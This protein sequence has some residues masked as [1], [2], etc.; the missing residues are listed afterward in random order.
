MHVVD[1]KP[2]TVDELVEPV[3]TSIVEASR[4]AGV[5]PIDGIKG[6]SQGIIQ[7][8]AET[9]I[10]LSEATKRILEAARKIAEQMGIPEE[11]AIIKAAE[12][13]LSAAEE[14]G[15]EAAAEVVDDLP[16][17]IFSEHEKRQKSQEN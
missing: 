2:L 9:G 13:V 12:G 1:E 17:K 7:G 5:K 10:D 15:P 11:E 3:A 14:I 8:A 4:N 6:V 16:E